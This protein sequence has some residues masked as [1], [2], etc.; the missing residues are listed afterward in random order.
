MQLQGGNPGRL[1]YSWS[2][3]LANG[4]PSLDNQEMA[5]LDNLNTTLQGLSQNTVEYTIK[6]NSSAIFNKV[7]EIT[8]RVS[9]FLGDHTDGTIQVMRE[10]KQL[11]MAQLDKRQ[12]SSKVSED[13]ELYGNFFDLHL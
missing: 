9:N 11:P 3:A 4:Q 2:A 12:L 5:I 7:I 8:V 13:I 10:N 1:T 6:P